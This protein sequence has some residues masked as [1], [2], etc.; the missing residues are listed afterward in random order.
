MLGPTDHEI[1]GCCI[2]AATKD[3]ARFG[4]FILDGAMIDGES[5]V[6][7]GW[8][9][10]ATTK[11]AD[12]GQAG[13]G[14]G[15]QWWTWD[16]GSFQGRGIFGQGIYIHPE[17]QLVIAVNSSWASAAPAKEKRLRQEMYETILGAVE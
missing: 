1:S 12:I 3:Y 6:P 2:Q 9:A 17:A 13:R 4:Q 8:F 7:E 10:K 16:D 15:Y 11:Q 14:Y 5:I